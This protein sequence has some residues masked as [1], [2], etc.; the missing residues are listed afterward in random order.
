MTYKKWTITSDKF[1]SENEIKGLLRHLETEMASSLTRGGSFQLVRDYYA[2]RC[3]LET[4]SRV[5]EFCDLLNSDVRDNKVIIRKGKGNKPRTVLLTK[6]TS[7]LLKEWNQV[8]YRQGFVNNSEDPLFPN[9]RNEKYCTRAIQKRIKLIFEVAGLP[10][11][12]SVH[13]LRHTYCSLLL[14]Q[15]VSLA[16]VKEQLG[17]SSISITNLYSH[18]IGNLDDVELYPQNFSYKNTKDELLNEDQNQQNWMLGNK[19]KKVS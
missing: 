2:V 11:N 3:L 17:H 6:A 14:A 5:F 13:S 9:S 12:L 4:G 1:L 7:K 8:K 19:D 15:K 18:A 10:K 16:T